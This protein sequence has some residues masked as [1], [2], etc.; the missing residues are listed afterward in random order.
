MVGA[1]GHSLISTLGIFDTKHKK[2]E[3]VKKT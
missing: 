1:Y 3:V 2:Q